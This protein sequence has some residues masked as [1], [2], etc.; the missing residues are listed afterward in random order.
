MHPMK[1]FTLPTDWT[2]E[3]ALTVVDLLDELREHIWAIYE[4]RLLDEYRDRYAC[5]SS[6]DAPPCIGDDPF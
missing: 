5:D 3:Q 1:P 4:I 2:A 6:A